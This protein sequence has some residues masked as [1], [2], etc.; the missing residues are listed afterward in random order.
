MIG[1]PVQPEEPIMA[2]TLNP[3][4][5]L[6]GNA[7]DALEFYQSVFG[8]D[9]TLMTFADGGTEAG[10]EDAD[11]IMHGQL[12]SA[13]G[14]TLMVADAPSSMPTTPGQNI[15]ISLS[16]GPDEEADLRGY[17][18]GL[19]DGGTPTVPLETAPWGDTFGMFVD[20]FGVD[21]MVNISGAAA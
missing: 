19:S 18:A 17:F 21:W 7:K 14:L 13:A 12:V 4:I 3:Y 11:R 8:G 6:D 5:H 20:K 15:S 9:L 16:G 2:T 10:P 1:I